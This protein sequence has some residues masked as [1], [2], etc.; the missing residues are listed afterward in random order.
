M[1]IK[2][3][4]KTKYVGMPMENGTFTTFYRL[5]NRKTIGFKD[6][7]SKKLAQEAYDFQKTLAAYDM[8]PMVYGKVR[9]IDYLDSYG[10][11]RKSNW[12]YV[13]EIAKTIDDSEYN[14]DDELHDNIRDEIDNLRD[15]ME[16]FLGISFYDCHFGNVGYVK[17]NG[18]DVL[19]CIDT[20][21][22]SFSGR[23]AY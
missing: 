12:G 20:G 6:F 5:K 8:A 10:I 21:E 17:R 4:V 1:M 2:A 14:T 16:M 22:E 11:K 18:Q 15:E 3:K 9:K 13:T 19:V 7:E 23:Y